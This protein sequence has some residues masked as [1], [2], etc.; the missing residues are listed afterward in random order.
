LL[1]GPI[2]PELGDLREL[3]EL[4][5]YNNKLTVKLTIFASR[6]NKLLAL[7]LGESRRCLLRSTRWLA[8]PIPS[9]LGHLSALEE[10][11]LQHNQ[12]SG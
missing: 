4:W 1:A 12:L 5:L 10:L 11:Y 7:I 3:R 8:G 6:F 9:E 2:P